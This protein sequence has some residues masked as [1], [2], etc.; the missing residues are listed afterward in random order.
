MRTGLELDYVLM[1][2]RI[3]KAAPALGEPAPG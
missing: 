1:G 3:Q 2:K